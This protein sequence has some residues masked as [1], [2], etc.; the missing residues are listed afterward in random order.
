MLMGMDLLCFNLSV[1][2]EHATKV[3]LHNLVG[4]TGHYGMEM[5]PTISEVRIYVVD[6]KMAHLFV[7]NRYL[8]IY[9]DGVKY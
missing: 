9:S 8:P 2:A 3:Y 1:L 5:L 4:V 6:Y 7:Q